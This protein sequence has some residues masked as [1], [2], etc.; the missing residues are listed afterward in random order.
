MLPAEQWVS[1]LP[2]SL[3]HHKAPTLFCRIN[4]EILCGPLCFAI[5]SCFTVSNFS[6]LCAGCVLTSEWFIW[7][8][9]AKVLITAHSNLKVDCTYFANSWSSTYC[10]C[11]KRGWQLVYPLFNTNLVT[12]ATA[13]HVRRMVC[14]WWC[15]F[16]DT[17]DT[18]L[19]EWKQKWSKQSRGEGEQ[20]QANVKKISVH[21]ILNRYIRIRSFGSIL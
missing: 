7:E 21:R 8:P 9:I 10:H 13:R 4:C 3:P 11:D 16:F 12:A 2:V 6:L 20:E 5:G 1:I 18:I 14:S 17:G 15:F 19:I